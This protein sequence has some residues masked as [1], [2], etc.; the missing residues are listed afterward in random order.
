MAGTFL[1]S[2]QDPASDYPKKKGAS[3]YVYDK[4]NVCEAGNR[5]A[6]VFVTAVYC[7][8]GFR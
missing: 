5:T 4:G 1:D 7:S 6:V 2:G 3:E 8:A